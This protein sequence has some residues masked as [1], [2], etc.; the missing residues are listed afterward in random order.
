MVIQNNSC[1]VA[2]GHRQEEEINFVESFA[3]VA[4]LEAV[5]I[6][7]AHAA[8]K[9]FHIYQMDIKTEF[10]N[11]LLKEE[12]FVCQPDRFVD[13]DFPNHV[14][15]LKKAIYGLKQA[16]R[17]WY[18]KLSSFLIEHHFTKDADLAGCNDDCKSTSGD[19][20]FLGDKLVSWS[21]KKQDCTA[22]STV[23]AEYVS[24]FAGCAQVI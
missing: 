15:S 8:H 18:D 5:R 3:P 2:K 19:I 12:V 6:F 10:L 17:A 11:G 20:Q 14:Y 1:L 24:L 22:M 16:P 23:E 4:R 7:T 21:S 9:N 13:P